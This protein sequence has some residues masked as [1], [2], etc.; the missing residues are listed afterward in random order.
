VSAAICPLVSCPPPLLYMSCSPLL[1]VNFK[2]AIYGMI[3]SR[4]LKAEGGTTPHPPLP[5][6]TP[7]PTPPPLFPLGPRIGPRVATCNPL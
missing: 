2:C 7:T 4:E 6:P 5:L 1:P 3:V